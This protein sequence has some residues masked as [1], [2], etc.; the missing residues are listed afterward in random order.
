MSIPRI[1]GY[2]VP[3]SRRTLASEWDRPDGE[4]PEA[5]WPKGVLEGI[6]SD[7]TGW[8]TVSEHFF[9]DD[10][11]GGFACVLISMDNVE[12]A[13]EHDTWL[14]SNLGDFGVFSDGSFEDGLAE[15]DRGVEVEFFCQVR[16]HHGLRLPTVDVALPFLWYWDAIPTNDGWYHL[17]RAGRDQ[18]LIRTNIEVD[19]WRVEVRAFELRHFLAET[20]RAALVQFDHVELQGTEPFERVDSDHASDWVRAS[21]HCLADRAID[22]RSFSRLMGQYVIGPLRSRGPRWAERREERKYPEFQYAVDPNT[23]A[24]LRHTCDPDQLGTYFDKDQSRPH[25]LTP[26]SFDRA[27]LGRYVDEPT[28]YNVTATRLSCLD[29]WGL[30]ISTNTAG[31]IEVYL[32]D[33]GRDLPSDEWPHW[34]GHNV[35]PEGHMAEDRFRRDIL[36]QPWPSIDLPR[37]LRQARQTVAAAAEELLGS[38]VWRRLQE[39]EATEFERLHGP[40]SNEPRSLNNPVL[41]LTKALVDAIDPKP[42]RT[43]LGETNRQIGS[44]ALLE[45][46]E[47][48]L[49]GDGRA[50]SML[51]DL[52]HLRSA[53]GIAHLSGSG[54]DSAIDRIG[55]T[56]MTPPQ[57]F[58]HICT[59]TAKALERLT[60]LFSIT[61]SD[62]AGETAED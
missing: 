12:A 44:L 59:R 21:W 48:Q 45:R 10:R 26:V 19:R 17:N 28:R 37:R 38:P 11:H 34:L 4:F 36:N 7:S 22:E 47:N 61:S 15:M 25:Y 2:T 13:L 9:E 1:P 30:A 5:L 20:G 6:S 16:G 43:F 40:T 3:P 57:A 53:G 39:P 14:G 35:A 49:G 55:I 46:V 42:L 51:R 27:V 32:G 24:A 54:R 41:T 50:T 31:Q 8:V 29:L 18:P 52:Q 56:A 62:S 60:R 58:D 23:G 33:L